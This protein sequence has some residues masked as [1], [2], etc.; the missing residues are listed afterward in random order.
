MKGGG[1]AMESA[2]T[3]GMSQEEVL[4]EWVRLYAGMLLK[5]CFL[6]L[7]D[8]HLAQDAMQDTFMKAWK[9]LTKMDQALLRSEK[10]W[11]TRIAVNTCRDYRRSQWFKRMDFAAELDRLPMDLIALPQQ[12]RE[13]LMEIGSLPDKLKHP[14]LLYYYHNLTLQDTAEA[15]DIPKSTAAKRLKK[16]EETLKRR[17]MGGEAQ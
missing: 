13:L 8:W 11:L 3:P 9:Q 7:G 15:L 1:E 6:C 5:T 12:D 17:I 2:V 10:A 4:E 16:A 14:V